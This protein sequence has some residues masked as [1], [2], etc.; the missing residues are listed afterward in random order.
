M[1]LKNILK[2]KKVLKKSHTFEAFKSQ[3]SG[4]NLLGNET[5]VCYNF[6]TKRGGLQTGY[7]FSSPVL[8]V[9]D[10]SGLMRE[11]FIGSGEKCDLWHFRCF[12]TATNARIDKVFFSYADFS[13]G[14]FDLFGYS[15]NATA[16]ETSFDSLP[17]GINFTVDD[18]DVILF[19]TDGSLVTFAVGTSAMKTAVLPKFVDLCS[20]HGRLF[21]VVAGKQN[22]ILFSETLDPSLWTAEESAITLDEFQGACNKLIY[23]ED[24]IFAFRDYGITKISEYGTARE[25]VMYDVFSTKSK[26]YGKSVVR[27]GE[28]ILF[29]ARDGLYTFNGGT[30]KQILPLFSS[31]LEGV[32]NENAVACFDGENYYLAC[33][34]NFRDFQTV[35]AE[36]YEGGY[37]NNALVVLNVQSGDAHIMRGM[38]IR[39]MVSANAGDVCNVF[40]TFYGQH[41]EKIGMLDLSGAMFGAHLPKVWKSKMN[42]FGTPEKIKNFRKIVFDAPKD[43]ILTVKTDLEQQSFVVVGQ[44]NLQEISTFVRGRKLWLEFSA[45]ADAEI[46]PAKVCYEETSK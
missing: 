31:Y 8:S 10:D 41:K 32:C 26:I 23:F 6:I 25:F 35:G 24:D 12:N 22:K 33:R 17:T 1:F 30:A 46:Y 3:I 38:D 36:N 19:S 18:Q 7:G 13:L 5:R 4:K 20:A 14:Y 16:L 15:Q 39:S 2:T 44:E 11:I 27:C 34:L 45:E 9:G 43:C 40:A 37:T 42:N 28:E 21:G 29:L